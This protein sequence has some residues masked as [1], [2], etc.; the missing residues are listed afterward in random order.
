MK[1]V[2][3][4][5]LY[6]YIVGQQISTAQGLAARLSVFRSLLFVHSE[7]V[8]G[9]CIRRNDAATFRTCLTISL[10][11]VFVSSSLFYHDNYYR[12]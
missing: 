5:N 8:S 7:N 2:G 1:E 6:V 9:N 12:V 11:A 3:R 4:W 10:F